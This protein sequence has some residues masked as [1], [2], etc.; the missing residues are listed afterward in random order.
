M[1]KNLYVLPKLTSFTT[2]IPEESIS[3]C[4]MLGKVG[5]PKPISISFKVHTGSVGLHAFVIDHS[6]LPYKNELTAPGECPAV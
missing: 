4:M 2:T 5:Y 6:C 3:C 1:T